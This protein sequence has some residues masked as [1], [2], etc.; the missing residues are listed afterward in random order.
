MRGCLSIIIGFV[1]FIGLSVLAGQMLGPVKCRD[2]WASG[3]IGRQGACS[4]HGGVD[5]SRGALSFVFMVIGGVAGFGFYGSKFADRLDQPRRPP[6]SSQ[7]PANRSAPPDPS[8]PDST[9]KTVAP[10][11]PP[12]PRQPKPIIPARP[13][14]KACPKCGSG[15]RLRTARHGPRRGKKFW[16]CNRY[17]DCKGAINVDRKR[18]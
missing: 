9:P 11:A 17:P 2:G 4:W 16:G 6:Q 14:S 12:E 10:L 7:P 8:S 1:A 3:S 15:M 18:P 13:G 5:R